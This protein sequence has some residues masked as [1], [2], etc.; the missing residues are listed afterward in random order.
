MTRDSPRPLVSVIMNCFNGEA[1]L[2]EAM[3]SVVAQ[4]WPAWE[5]VFWDNGSTDASADIAR[6]YGSRV[7]YFR[8]VETVPLGAARNLAIREAE[9]EYITFLDVDDVWLPETVATLVAEMETGEWAVCYAGIYQMNAA[10]QTLGTRIPAPRRG[11]LL[12]ALLR[13][14][15]IWVPALIV[16][17]KALEASGLSFDPRIVAS[18]EYCLF[19]QLAAS[20]PFCSLSMPLARYRIHDKALTNASIGKWADE[21]E[22]TL[23]RVKEANPG[24]EKR[25]RRAFREAYARARYYRARWYLSRGDRRQAIA[26]LSRTVL[27]DVRYALLFMLALLPTAAW[28]AVHRA[29][30]HRSVY[31]T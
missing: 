22:Y 19:V 21:R 25:H 18:E 14:F 23:A 17:R 12:D 5:I 24:I 31:G 6:S 20:L 15:D 16:N 7:R 1:F 27:V 9:G 30:S 4:T 8:S 2:R 10:G 28:D 29:R 11:D 3:D 13:D 26:Q